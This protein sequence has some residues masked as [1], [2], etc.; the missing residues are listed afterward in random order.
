MLSDN[1]RS[2]AGK[3]YQLA[4]TINKPRAIQRPHPPIVI[5]GRTKDAAH[6]R[7]YADATNLIVPDPETVAPRLTQ[8][9]VRNRD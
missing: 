1:E 2:F 5:G 7:P 6:G 3:H 4:E 8:V 9:E